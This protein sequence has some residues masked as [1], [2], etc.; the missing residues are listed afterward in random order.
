MRNKTLQYGERE[1]L[2]AHEF[3]LSHVGNLNVNNISA[4]TLF[5]HRTMR[6]MGARTNMYV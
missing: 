2:C 5:R 3:R 6:Q 4:K 1:W